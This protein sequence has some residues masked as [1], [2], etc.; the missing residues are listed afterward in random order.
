MGLADDRIPL[1]AWWLLTNTTYGTWLPGDPRGSVTSVRDRRPGE[2][3]SEVRLEHDLPGQEPEPY[4]PGLYRASLEQLKGPPIY[5]DLAQAE[6]VLGQFQETAAYRGWLLRAA[7]IMC[8]HFHLVVRAP[9]EVDPGKMLADFKAYASRVLNRRYG[10]PPSEKWW[11]TRGSKRK[12]KTDDYFLT[13]I[14]YVLEK[15]ESP[16]VLFDSESDRESEPQ[17]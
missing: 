13:A 14:K 12:L 9:D 7:A 8:N 16:L 6:L 15:Q 3:E 5:L 10:V 11:T 2:P 4:I 17:A 1:M